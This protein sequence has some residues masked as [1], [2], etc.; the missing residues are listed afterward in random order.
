MK[1]KINVK[2]TLNFILLIVVGACLG[3]WLGYYYGEQEL[4]ILGL[5]LSIV[6]IVIAFILHVI[7]HE[8]GHLV[9]GLLTGYD[10][11]SFRIFSYSLVKADG[12]YHFVKLKIPGMLGQCLMVPTSNIKDFKYKLYLLGGVLANII[13]SAL[14]LI[15]I[16]LS[17]DFVI[18]FII[19]GL[20]LAV[21][22]FIPASF[23][24]GATLKLAKASPENEKLFFIQ[25][26]ANAK[27]SLGATYKELPEWYF[28]EVS[29]NSTYFTDYQLFLKIGLCY[30]N[31]E[32]IKAKEI[33]D[34]MWLRK[35]ELVLPYQLEMKKELLFCLLLLDSEDSRID[36]LSQNKKLL[37]NLKL[38]D[39]SN[40]KILASL[41]FIKEKNIDKALAIVELGINWTNKVAN[42]GG[43]IV[44]KQVLYYLKDL[45]QAEI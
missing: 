32:F 26:D 43:T 22:N 21:T 29:T 9:F 10:F 27:M 3:G 31:Q 4:N 1:K 30:E 6:F 33:L 20:F 39:V 24:D 44:E 42:I 19:I 12:A 45:W 17:F 25:L 40:Q 36:E 13:A 14:S 38:N 34:T 37:A 41:A 18:I 11:L 23:N 8:G 15:F 16:K 35:D 7:I 2:K 5:M 28:E